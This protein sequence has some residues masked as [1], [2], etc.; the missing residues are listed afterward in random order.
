LPETSATSN[1][2]KP[3]EFPFDE[4]K[5]LAAAAV[6]LKKASGEM[7]YFRLIKLIYIADRV[8]I[9]YRG[10]PIVGG[11]YVSMDN[12]PVNSQV[13][14]LVKYGGE[15]WSTTIEKKN[16]DVRLIAEFDRG[17]LSN[18]E[19]ALLHEVDDMLK[20][21]DQWQIRD[22]L[23]CL[24]EWKDPKGGSIPI[25]PEEILRALELPEEKI[26]EIRQDI[27]EREYFD[28]IFGV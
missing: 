28:E 10:H 27:I 2:L 24:P 13:F 22:I 1:P 14:D 9:A 20:K 18:E 11:F 4:R 8:S 23:H 7:R 5:A 15:I 19:I 12:G 16:Y 17:P 26:E 25:S 6:L 3:I 21:M